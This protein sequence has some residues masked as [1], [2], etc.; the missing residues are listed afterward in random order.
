MC[1]LLPPA[2]VPL[3]VLDLSVSCCD[4]SSAS[5]NQ[6]VKT[7]MEVLNSNEGRA[8]AKKLQL[9]SRTNTAGNESVLLALLDEAGG[10]VRLFVYS[11]YLWSCELLLTG[12]VCTCDE[13]TR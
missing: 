9:N 2:K 3:C 1:L 12:T 8:S 5:A 10:N 11:L 6:C 13:G 4:I 7:E